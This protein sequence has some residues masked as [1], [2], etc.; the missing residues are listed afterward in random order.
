M[1]TEATPEGKHWGDNL[2]CSEP[3]ILL[4]VSVQIHTSAK[5]CLQR[6]GTYYKFT[7][8]RST[9]SKLPLHLFSRLGGLH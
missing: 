7:T 9:C 1:V 8:N 4:M 2:S 5:A 6:K 3:D